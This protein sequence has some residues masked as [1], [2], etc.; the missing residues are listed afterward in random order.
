MQP[1][2]KSIEP[3]RTILVITVGFIAVYLLTTWRPC[4]YAAVTIG[5][6]GLASAYLANKIHFLWMKLAWLLGFIVPN[7]LL[8]LV[9]FLIL[10]PVAWMSRLFGQKNQLSLKNTMDSL[11]IERNKDFPKS[12]FEKTW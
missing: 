10:T 2:L 6:A 12:I 3:L 1:H 8:A 5:A 7:I 11:F 4:L 9:F